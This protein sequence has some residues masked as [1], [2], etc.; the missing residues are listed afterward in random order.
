[1]DAQHALPAG[2]NSGK[3]T[4]A[5]RT[6]SEN[7]KKINPAGRAVLI[8]IFFDTDSLFCPQGVSLSMF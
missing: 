4:A 1:M 3:A 8:K 5:C 2:K 6:N 7:R